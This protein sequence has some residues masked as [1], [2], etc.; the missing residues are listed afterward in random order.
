MVIF[1][2]LFA[3]IVTPAEGSPDSESPESKSQEL[4][5]PEPSP[6]PS[7]EHRNGLSL[8]FEAGRGLLFEEN[9]QSSIKHEGGDQLG[10]GDVNTTLKV[11]DQLD[12]LARDLDTMTG[13]GIPSHKA[14]DTDKNPKLAVDTENTARPSMPRRIGNAFAN[15]ATATPR[16]LDF[17]GGFFGNTAAE[18]D[19]MEERSLGDDTF[20]TAHTSVTRPSLANTAA[21]DTAEERSLG[22]DT[23]VT[24]HTRRSRRS[25]AGQRSKDP[26]FVE[27]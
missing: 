16:A 18:A 25:N 12:N 14:N 21:A 9:S 3:I 17:V 11:V 19:T 4:E 1:H 5:S 6:E 2:V 24:A 22:D 8:L 7:P 27:R 13:N 26:N 10:G 20:A 23:F 15:V